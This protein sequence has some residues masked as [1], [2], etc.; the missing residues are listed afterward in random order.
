MSKKP[1]TNANA[2]ADKISA[3]RPGAGWKEC[4]HCHKWIKGLTTKTCYSCGKPFAFANANAPRGKPA[5]PAAIH[6]FGAT[7]NTLKLVKGFID[8][9]KGFDTA[10]KAVEKMEALTIACG[11][12]EQLYKAI[13]TLKA[14]K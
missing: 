14:F 8:D 9:N 4:H 12:Y 3:T 11:S 2:N 7:A 13:E 10:K 5:P 1:E 6:D